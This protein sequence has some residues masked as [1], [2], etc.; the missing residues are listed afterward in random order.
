MRRLI[1]TVLLSVI[2]TGGVLAESET[3]LPES[4]RLKLNSLELVLVDIEN[5]LNQMQS[6]YDALLM[7]NEAAQT[8]LK[9]RIDF[10]EKEQARLNEERKRLQKDIDLLKNSEKTWPELKRSYE[11]EINL[12]DWLSS[13][14]IGVGVG[15][16]VYA[17]SED[18][19]A[20]LGSAI[21]S[22]ALTFFLL[23]IF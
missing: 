1:C 14:G 3:S 20:S 4:M 17:L 18:P 15:M 11:A 8:A 19:W 10:L 16:T 2:L 23:K 6:I 22:G 12:R 7:R 21:G 5:E 13:A 9:R